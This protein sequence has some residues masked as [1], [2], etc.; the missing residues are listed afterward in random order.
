VSQFDDPGPLPQH[1]DRTGLPAVSATA[2]AWRV[3]PNW[4]PYSTVFNKYPAGTRVWRP[5][6]NTFGV[7][8]GLSEANAPLIMWNGDDRA[9]PINTAGQLDDIKMGDIK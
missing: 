8:Q 1:A 3:K 6:T 5:S 4:H 2:A 9:T 7:Y